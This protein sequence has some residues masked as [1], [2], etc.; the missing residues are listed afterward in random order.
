[1]LWNLYTVP[2]RTRWVELGVYE[3]AADGKFQG[4][5]KAFAIN[6]AYADVWWCGGGGTSDLFPSDAVN[7]S[8]VWISED[9]WGRKAILVFLSVSVGFNHCSLVFASLPIARPTAIQVAPQAVPDS[10]NLSF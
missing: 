9:C 3:E 10:S 4:F 6:G 8:T 7:P 1:M 2:V 5:C